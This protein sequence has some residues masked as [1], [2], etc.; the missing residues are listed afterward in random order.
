MH[1]AVVRTVLVGWAK[2]PADARVDAWRSRRRLE[3][4]ISH[5]ENP[6]LGVLDRRTQTGL[7]GETEREARVFGSNDAIIPESV[8]SVCEGGTRKLALHSSSTDD[9]LSRTGRGWAV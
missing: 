4:M 2:I 7:Q 5:S 9:P 1:G 6:K 8:R 3:R